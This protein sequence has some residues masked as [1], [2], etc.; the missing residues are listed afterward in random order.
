MDLAS[1]YRPGLRAPSLIFFRPGV[2]SNRPA[3]TEISNKN[4]TD[5]DRQEICFSSRAPEEVIPI[6]FI[7]Q[8]CFT[9]SQDKTAKNLMFP[10]T[11]FVESLWD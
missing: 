11:L 4:G 7:V 8:V 9:L 3:T 2:A 10:K 5:V 6:N 1:L